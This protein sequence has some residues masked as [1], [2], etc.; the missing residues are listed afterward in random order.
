MAAAMI[1]SSVSFSKCI[2]SDFFNSNFY[3]FWPNLNGLCFGMD[4]DSLESVVYPNLRTIL[5]DYNTQ[6]S[7]KHKKIEMWRDSI[8]FT[9][10]FSD[11]DYPYADVF[12]PNYY[13]NDINY[14]KP[15]KAYYFGINT[16]YV[17]NRNTND[18]FMVF[19]FY[20]G[21][22]KKFY[23]HYLNRYGNNGIVSGLFDIAIPFDDEEFINTILDTFGYVRPCGRFKYNCSQDAGDLKWI[24]VKDTMVNIFINPKW[25]RMHVRENCNFK[26]SFPEA[27]IENI[28]IR[29][30]KTTRDKFKDLD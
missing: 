5:S 24:K 18:T 10:W 22:S 8:N 23:N 25:Q 30:D 14:I 7:T 3:H 15:L 11:F 27:L 20:N 12:T 4:E 6:N 28:K 9:N 2:G 13:L 29:I 26:Y 21:V 1:L 19:T 17:G 16:I